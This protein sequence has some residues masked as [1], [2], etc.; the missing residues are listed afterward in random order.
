M[1]SCHISKH[2]EN[3]LLHFHV[4]LQPADSAIFVVYDHAFYL[5]DIYWVLLEVHLS[6]K[7]T[8]CGH[9]QDLAYDGHSV[10]FHGK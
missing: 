4:V 2:P 8:F 10:T 6:L 1:L 7:K 9:K 3:E 5:G